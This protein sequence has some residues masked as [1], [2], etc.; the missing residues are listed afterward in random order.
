MHEVYMKL[1]I[2]LAKKGIGSVNPN[3][4]VGAV[5]VKEG[6][7]IAQGYHSG[8][9]C[10]HA[11][12]NAFKQAKA[13]L[14]G[15]TL[16]VTLEPCSHYGKTP[17][18][19]LAIIEQGI[20][21]VHIASQDPN[22]LVSGKGIA[23]LNAAGITTHVGV[24]DEENRELNKFFFTAMNEKRPYVMIKTAMSLDGKI[25]TNT[26]ES[27][28]ITSEAS[29][30]VVHE[31]RNQYQGIMVGINTILKDDPLLTTRLGDK[32]GRNAIR[33][34]VDSKGRIPL[35]SLVVQTASKIK[36]IIACTS[37]QP[38]KRTALEN[39]HVDV[40][41][42]PEKEG[43]V[44]LIALMQVLHERGINSVMIEGGQTLNA[45]ALKAGIVDEVIAFV[46]PLII[47]GQSSLSAF[48]GQGIDA[49]KEAHRLRL[50][51][52]KTL[53]EDMMLT[54]QVVKGDN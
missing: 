27:K 8:F 2:D 50:K 12:I 44:D 10:E 37:I 36:T 30:R 9:G 29:R 45:E 39:H 54:Y 53:Q 41:L 16:Y 26:G 20:K 11:E 3:P 33:I 35:S 52:V 5:V 34:I 21:T 32:E 40:I 22:P 43:R 1:A 42:I 31:L 46:A 51:E 23:M 19:S 38:H 7:I 13:P 49:L 17:P 15:S 6:E 24:L 25:G 47:T 28:W 48:G 18:C 14:S 4:L